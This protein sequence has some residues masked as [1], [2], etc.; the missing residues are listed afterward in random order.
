MS[1]LLA[2]NEYV[3]KESYKKFIGKDYKNKQF[4]YIILVI[5]WSGMG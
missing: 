3:I 4:C 1:Y 2:L 5:L